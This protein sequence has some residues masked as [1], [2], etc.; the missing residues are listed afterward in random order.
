MV[1]SGGLHQEVTLAI[2]LLDRT[3][4]QFTSVQSAK[5]LPS[6]MAYRDWL[7]ENCCDSGA[8]VIKILNYFLISYFMF[9]AATYTK[10][11]VSCYYIK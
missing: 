1:F 3:S 4:V 8:S 6:C 2:D 10:K 7:S 11:K 5:T 9:F